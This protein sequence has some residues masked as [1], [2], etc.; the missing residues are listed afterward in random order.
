MNDENDSDDSDTIMEM[1]SV[2]PVKI[3]LNKKKKMI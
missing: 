3:A 1:L 2:A